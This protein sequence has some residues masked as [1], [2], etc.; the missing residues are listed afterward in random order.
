MSTSALWP[1]ADS[2][3]FSACRKEDLDRFAAA[4][5]ASATAAGSGSVSLTATLT[6]GSLGATSSATQAIGGPNGNGSTIP[7]Q[8]GSIIDPAG[9]SNTTILHVPTGNKRLTGGSVAGVAIGM[10][11]AGALIAGAVFLFLLRRQKRR[12]AMS[13]AA[14]SQQHASYTERNIRPEKGATVVAASVGSIDDLLPQPA[15]DDAIT[16]DLSKIRDN[17]RNHVR[18]YYHS[19][20]ISTTNINEAGIRDIAASTG[21]SAAVIAKALADP[22]TRDNALRSIVGSVILTRCTG[23]RS[24]S[25]L[26]NDVAALSASIPASNENNYPSRA[27]AFQDTAASLDSILAP[28][29]KG[30]VDGSQRR[31]NLDMILT[32]A[33]RFAFLLFAQPG[34]FR[35]DFASQQGGLTVFPALV[36]TVGD[37]G[38]SLSPIKVLTEKEVVAA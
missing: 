14:Y 3:N 34:T 38:Q 30:S 18:T 16:G 35:F 22:L 19:E 32:R 11:L 17:I 25:L 1:I 20:P 23:E 12:Q 5:A 33:A 26:P 13:A 36:Q 9:A 6:S 27:Q 28:F 37:Q 21:T 31:K 15:E 2:N 29:V 24:P 8:T 10:L 7:S 4:S